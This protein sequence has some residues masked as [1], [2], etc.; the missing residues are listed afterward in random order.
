[1]PHWLCIALTHP[2]LDRHLWPAP[3]ALQEPRNRVS[4]RAPPSVE[5]G[6]VLGRSNREVRL[7]SW[8]AA[9]PEEEREEQREA[10][11]VPTSPAHRRSP[12]G[13]PHSRP[14]GGRRRGSSREPSE[15]RR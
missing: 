14:D 4:L 9:E 3:S 12:A 5:D 1:M 13:Q 6:P 15:R 7:R 11:D 10:R 2:R 8:Q